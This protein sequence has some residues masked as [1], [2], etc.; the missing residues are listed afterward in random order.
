MAQFAS[1]AERAMSEAGERNQK[2]KKVSGKIFQAQGKE[3]LKG[4]N[5]S[6]VKRKN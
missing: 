3:K 6:E 2:K 1:V 4:K 5:R